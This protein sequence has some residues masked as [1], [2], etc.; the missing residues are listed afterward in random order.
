MNRQI[1][2]CVCNTRIHYLTIKKFFPNLTKALWDH[3]GGERKWKFP[4][5]P[6][7][8]RETQYE[9]KD[10]CNPKFV[11]LSSVVSRIE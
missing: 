2:Y 4:A 1:H 5:A 7:D 9:R 3:S 6:D 10:D 8:Y 11:V